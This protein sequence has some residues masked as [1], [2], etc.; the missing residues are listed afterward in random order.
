MALKHECKQE[1]IWNHIKQEGQ[2]ND[3][4]YMLHTTCMTWIGNIVIMPIITF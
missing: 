4:N 3:H 1:I 2:W